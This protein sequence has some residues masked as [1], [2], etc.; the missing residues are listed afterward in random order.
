[1]SYIQTKQFTNKYYIFNEYDKDENI[2][3]HTTSNQTK[4]DILNKGLTGNT[5]EK[6]NCLIQG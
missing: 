5:F 3:I 1:M 4:Q 6:I 2:A